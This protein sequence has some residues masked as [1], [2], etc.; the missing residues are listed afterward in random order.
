MENE[1][2]PERDKLDTY[3]AKTFTDSPQRTSE[4]TSS[5][6]SVEPTLRALTSAAIVQQGSYQSCVASPSENETG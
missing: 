5:K 3:I 1:H 6:H 2:V 4:T